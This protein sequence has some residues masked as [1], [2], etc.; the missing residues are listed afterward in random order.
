MEKEKKTHSSFNTKDSLSENHKATHVEKTVWKILRRGLIAEA[1]FRASDF[2]K[3]YF[4][5]AD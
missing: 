2:K 5:P 4:I 1:P 3:A